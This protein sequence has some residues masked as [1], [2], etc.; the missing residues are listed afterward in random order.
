MNAAQHGGARGDAAGVA[1]QTGGPSEVTLPLGPVVSST[2]RIG[3]NSVLKL[4]L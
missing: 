1:A 2:P 3:N 4:M